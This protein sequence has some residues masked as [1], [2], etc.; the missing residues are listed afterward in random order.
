[1]SSRVKSFFVQSLMVAVSVFGLSIIAFPSF[2]SDVC[3]SSAFQGMLENKHRAESIL[4]SATT[5]DISKAKVYVEFDGENLYYQSNFR[6]REENGQLFDYPTK[7][8]GNPTL[9]P[10]FAD[11]RGIF[12]EIIYDK[13]ANELENAALDKP[14]Q[15]SVE[16][17]V[18]VS[19]FD[20]NWRSRVDLTGLKNV[21]IVDGKTKYTYNVKPDVFTTNRPPPSLI[22][23]LK[24]CC[25][26]GRPP[27]L[28]TNILASLKAVIIEP[29]KVKFA[30]LF[31]DSATNLAI[32]T[33]SKVQASRLAGDG[34]K[35]R[36]RQ[37]FNAMVKK[38]ADNILVI[39]AHVEGK[40]YVIRDSAN[41]ETFRIAILDAREEAKTHN[42][43]LI[44]IGC[45][46]AQ[47]IDQA[48][49]GLGIMTRYNSVDAVRSIQKALSS[50][51]TLDEF[52]ETLSSDGMKIVVEPS[53]VT[54][55][56]RG[57]TIYS[58]IKS[59]AIEIWIK[60]AR[61]NF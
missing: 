33:S 36:T 8:K 38:A 7:V 40:D 48:S 28:W 25:L 50:T 35:M 29:S 45:E 57:A 12:T 42:V 51:K 4:T 17:Y 53:F 47:A 23:K 3:R 5:S 61:I 34:A 52:L 59:R 6:S 11:A 1:M 15:E 20:G 60:I 37:Q 39:I 2:A 41:K 31:N 27:H 13:Q 58:R 30:S 22:A 21:Q 14:W 46:T 56:V 43:R 26:Y 24:G 32:Q 9:R 49:G 16:F 18:D 55:N 19:V 44:D 54:P 10:V